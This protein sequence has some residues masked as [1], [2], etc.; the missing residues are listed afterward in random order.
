MDDVVQPAIDSIVEALQSIAGLED[1][2]FTLMSEEELFDRAK[3]LS[4]PAAGAVYAGLSPLG[5]SKSSHRMGAAALLS[6][7]VVVFYRTG[8]Q[9]GYPQADRFKS[10][11]LAVLYSIRRKLM[12]TAG[13]NG[14]TWRFVSELPALEKK[15]T[16]MWIQRWELPVVL[17]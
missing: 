13:P 9:V 11:A 4:A 3:L 2:S 15:G 1:K 6:A 17:L 12:D 10:D 16:V 7:V 8:V 14:K 5:E